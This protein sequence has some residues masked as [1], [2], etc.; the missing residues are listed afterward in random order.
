MLYLPYASKKT[1]NSYVLPLHHW[2]SIHM[3]RKKA[4]MT[5]QMNQARS[6]AS[7]GMNA[8]RGGNNGLAEQAFEKAIALGWPGAD[9]WVMLSLARARLG[10]MEGRRAALAEAL[11][12]NPTDLRARLYSAQLAA[13][14][15]DTQKALGLYRAAVAERANAPQSPELQQLFAE[16]DAF[17]TAN[18]AAQDP[19][20]AA[21]ANENIGSHPD[22][23]LFQQSLDIVS[24]KTHPYYSHPTRYLYPGLPNRQFFPREQFDWVAS[25]EANTQIIIDELTALL[26]GG[27]GTF[28]P[29]VESTG[30]E[31]AGVA[32][33]M[34]DDPAWSA[35]YLM[36]QGQRQDQNIALCPQ[37]WATIEALGANAMPGPAPSVLFSLLRPGARIPAHHGMLN[38]RLICHLPLI[39]PDD[40]GFRVGNDTRAW[41][42]GEMF[43]F[44]DTIE[45]EAWNNGNAPR[46]ILIF[47]CWRPELAQRQR[48]LLTQ[49]FSLQNS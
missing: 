9:V 12:L 30:R 28:A 3:H 27:Q 41:H 37:T 13:T 44:D 33:Q 7:T 16:A 39:I 22:D 40:C 14:S 15:G 19:F 49:L 1:A 34:E 48:D 6:F 26:N 21:F 42:P 10:N 5:D 47:E 23:E 32:L 31:S 25:V 46:Y 2:Q 17:I 36:K 38:T 11:T 4:S 45:H 43:L 8:L 29:Y 18:S 24:G 20:S 35:F